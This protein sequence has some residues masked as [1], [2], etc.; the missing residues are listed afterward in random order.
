MSQKMSDE[1]KIKRTY[2][3]YQDQDTWLD[4]KVKNWPVDKSWLLRRALYYYI[5][6][7]QYKDKRLRKELVKNGVN[8]PKKEKD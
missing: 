1:K 5:A 3:V 7:G 4:N 8:P 2:M 6:R